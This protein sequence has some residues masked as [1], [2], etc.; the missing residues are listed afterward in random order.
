MKQIAFVPFCIFLIAISTASAAV[1]VQI[2]VFCNG[3]VSYDNAVTVTKSN[4]TAFD[5]IK[6]SGV[7]HTGSD[8]GWGFFLTSI[9]GCGGS[10]GPAFYVNGAESDVGVSSYNLNEGDQLQFIGPNNDGPTAGYLYL[11]KVPDAV[12][13]GEG[14]RI[15]VMEKSAYAYGG[16][17]RP[18]SGATVTVGNKSFETGGDGYTSEITLKQDA[19]FCVAAEKSGYIATY[20]FYGLPYIQCGVGGPYICAITGEGITKANIYYDENSSISGRGFSSCRCYFENSGGEYPERSTEV[21][22][23]GSGS[24]SVEKIVKQRPSKIDIN[25]STEMNYSPVTFKAYDRPLCYASKYEDSLSQKN[26][27]KGSAFKE[28]YRQLDYLKREGIYNNSEKISFSLQS[29]FQGI[30]ELYART[31]DEDTFFARDKK[32]ELKEESYETYIGHF[33]IFR[34]GTVPMVNRTADEEDCEEDCKEHCEEHCQDCEDYC[35]EY[36]EK[37]CENES[38]GE[39]EHLPCCT[40]GWSNMYEAD[41]VGHSAKGIFDCSCSRKTATPVLIGQKA[42]G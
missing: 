10:W 15:K 18:S 30:A 22:Q 42:Y 36:C 38:Y 4:P 39:Y 16:Y 9:A 17:D 29:D 13:K 8:S 11:A 24:Y 1:T 40:G 2:T 20:Y 5:A 21:Y 31:L 37:H 7:A 12:A 27:Q 6:A 23:K 34:R 35:E 14:F 26:Y 41:Q 32:A 28:T 33:Q 25:E 3:G 19:Y